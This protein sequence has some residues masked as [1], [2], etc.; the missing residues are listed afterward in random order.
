MNR[1]N[2]YAAT[3]SAVRAHGGDSALVR[4]AR[5]EVVE[6]AEEGLGKPDGDLLGPKRLRRFHADPIRMLSGPVCRGVLD[7]AFR[8][9]CRPR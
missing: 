1:R 4:A 7:V 2:V 5:H 6:V 3:R 9:G 8:L